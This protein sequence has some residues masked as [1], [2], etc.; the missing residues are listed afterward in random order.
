MNT[1][2]ILA[3]LTLTTV[4]GDYFIKIASLPN[5]GMATAYFPVGLFFYAITGVGWFFMMRAHSLAAIGVLYSASTIILLA[6]L[7]VLIFKESFG[8]R[9]ALGIALALASVVVIGGKA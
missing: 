4:I 6:A 2:L 9:D 1:W 8:L 3:A 5:N 7:G